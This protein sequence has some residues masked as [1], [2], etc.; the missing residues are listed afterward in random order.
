MAVTD[1]D[2]LSAQALRVLG[3]VAGHEAARDGHDAVPRKALASRHDGPHGARGTRSA[4][5]LGHRRVGRDRAG[6]ID[7]TTSS[8]RASNSEPDA[9]IRKPTGACTTPP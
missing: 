3:L 4:G 6:G 7:R 1:A 9:M 8:T 5:L 2:A